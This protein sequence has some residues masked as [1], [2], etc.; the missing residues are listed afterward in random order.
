MK[1]VM[2]ILAVASL[3]V[4]GAVPAQ[5]D[6]ITVNVG[7]ISVTTPSTGTYSLAAIDLTPGYKWDLTRGDFTIEGIINLTGITA[8]INTWDGDP[9]DGVECLGVWYA[10][11]LSDPLTVNASNGVWHAGVQWTGG[12]DD[13]AT[14]IRDILHMQE[15]PGTQPSPIIWTEARTKADD[16]DDSYAFKIQLHA[17]DATSGWAKLWLNGTL[18]EEGGTDHLDF[19]GEDL[20]NAYAL[21]QIINGNNSNNAQNTLYFEDLV[22]TGTTVIPEPAGLGLIGLA[23]LAVRKKRN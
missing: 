22:V 9:N 18:L 1:R 2:M 8:H 7:D 4:A 14:E 5:A 19:T 10:V 20:S 16:S 12:G 13:L 15:E 6:T 17:N 3:M 21:A 11:G 23:L